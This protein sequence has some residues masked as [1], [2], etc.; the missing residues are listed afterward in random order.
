M[1]IAANNI[2]EYAESGYLLLKGLFSE[3]QIACIEESA[4]EVVHQMTG[5]LYNSL[6]CS[7]LRDKLAS[8][9]EFERS[10]YHELRKH[11]WLYE[12]CKADELVNPLRQIVSGSI[13]LMSK[14][15]FRIDLPRVTRELAVWHQDYHYVRGNT[16]ILTAWIPL[17]DTGFAQGCLL[18][19]PGSHLMGILSHDNQ[20]LGKRHFPS[21][22]FD[23]DVRYVEMK[24]GDVLIFH[25]LL[26]HSSGIN[27]SDQI[28]FS[29]QPRYT[30][31]S[32]STS[33]EMG[34]RIR[35]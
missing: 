21:G 20:I 2:C 33:P 25:S 11:P 9:R 32:L 8:E 14:I 12:F 27:L 30:P 6:H 34:A 16:E 19:M 5:I 29:L 26:L 24:K 18:V 15:P 1:K 22:I 28:R 13:D 23:R 7:K 3:R 35:C 10:L 31:G 4:L 17:Q